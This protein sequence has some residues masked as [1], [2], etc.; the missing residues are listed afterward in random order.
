MGFA[1]VPQTRAQHAQ[2]EQNLASVFKHVM[3]IKRK[4]PMGSGFHEHMMA[5]VRI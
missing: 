5:Q 4:Q 2:G 3:G 1:E